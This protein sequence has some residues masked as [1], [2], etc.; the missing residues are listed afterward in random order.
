[1]SK[2]ELAEPVPVAP[3]I[4]IVVGAVAVVCMFAAVLVG[5]V[6]GTVRLKSWL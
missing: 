4:A 6:Y 1:M 3:L 5:I 2:Q